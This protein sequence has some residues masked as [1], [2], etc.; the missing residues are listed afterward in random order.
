MS[1]VIPLGEKKTNRLRMTRCIGPWHLELGTSGGGTTLSLAIGERLVLGSGQGVDV[2]IEDDAVSQRHLELTATDAGLILQDLD[3]TNG[4]FV[5]AA[6]IRRAVLTG[7]AATIVLGRTTMSAQF[8]PPTSRDPGSHEVPGMVGKSAA[9]R[10]LAAEIKRYAKLNAPV[11][12]R[13]ETGSG[14]DVV[15]KALHQLGARKGAFVALNVGALSESLADAELFGHQR[16]AFTGAVT[17]RSGAFQDASDGTLFLDEIADLAPSIQVKLLRVLEDR[18]V[19]PLGGG[20]A[21]EVNA[22]IVSACWA[23]LD[24]LSSEG[25]FRLDLYHRISTVVLN[26]PPLRERKSDICYLS[27]ALLD[28]Q[29][30]ELGPKELTPRALARLVECDWPGNVRQLASTLYRAAVAAPGCVVDA[31]HVEAAIPS[32]RPRKITLTPDEATAFLRQHGGN[33]TRASRAIGVARSTFRAWLR[34]AC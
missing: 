31:S 7:S 23:D 4:T 13:G 9:M 8:A 34:R 14:K 11:L 26:V 27:R 33:V 15:A 25:R 21:R 30:S 19:R 18:R 32:H 10:A 5:G 6:Q 12:V 3:S 17:S 28:R 2:R 29:R 22:R 20:P 16:G 24:V 1:T